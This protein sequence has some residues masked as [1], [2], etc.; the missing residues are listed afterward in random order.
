MKGLKTGG[1]NEGT[2]NKITKE[3][4]EVIKGVIESE[5][6]TIEQTLSSLE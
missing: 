6:K 1:R 2:P 3:L 5:F 4:K